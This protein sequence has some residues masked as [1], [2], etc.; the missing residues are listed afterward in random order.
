VIEQ[1]FGVALEFAVGLQREAAAEAFGGALVQ[2]ARVEVDPG[3]GSPRDLVRRELV[4]PT[5][6]VPQARIVRARR[7]RAIDGGEA[8]TVRA[9]ARDQ[10]RGKM[11]ERVCVIGID[12]DGASREVDAR[13]DIARDVALACLI[14][15]CARVIG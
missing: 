8:L 3:R 1:V 5:E 2:V 7:R 10:Q 11:F 15:Q 6:R 13:A 9:A 4:A 14:E 12:G